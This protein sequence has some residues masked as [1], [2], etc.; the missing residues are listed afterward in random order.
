MNRVGR[1]C[2]NG[3]TEIWPDSPTEASGASCSVEFHVSN[4]SNVMSMD[5]VYGSAM[6]GVGGWGW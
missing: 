6:D 2:E 5:P 1:H 4:K 3:R